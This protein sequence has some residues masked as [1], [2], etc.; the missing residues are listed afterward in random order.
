MAATA[1]TGEIYAE[2]CG[3]FS[4]GR[5]LCHGHSFTGNPLAA[6]AACET[7]SII[8]EQNI[9]ESLEPLIAFFRQ[10]LETFGE[11]QEVG[12]I[13]GIGLIGAV[14][15]VADRGTKQ[16]FAPEKRVAFRVSQKALDKGL[17]VRPLGDVLYFVPAYII[18]EE[19]IE[20]MTDTLKQAI[21]EVI[22]E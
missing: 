15:L 14:E 4:A 20:T 17:L 9:P 3:D 5:E 13:R 18:T 19:Q 7:L 6:A 11:I 1:V 16:Q 8:M 2:F 21:K 22:H 10:R 12:D